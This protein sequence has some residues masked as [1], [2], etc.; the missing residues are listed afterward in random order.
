MKNIE[1]TNLHLTQIED[2]RHYFERLR[3]EDRQRSLSQNKINTI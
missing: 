2:W 1:G 3:T